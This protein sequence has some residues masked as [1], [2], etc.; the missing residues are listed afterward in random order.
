MFNNKIKKIQ[1]LKIFVFKTYNLSA[2]NPIGWS[3]F[4]CFVHLTNRKMPKHSRGHIR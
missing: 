1:K 2:Q 4:V 3:L